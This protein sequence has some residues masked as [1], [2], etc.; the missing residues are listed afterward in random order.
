MDDVI[1]EG[2]SIGAR[3]AKHSGE[4]VSVGL[5]TGVLATAVLPPDLDSLVKPISEGYFQ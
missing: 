3:A 2:G 1:K 4:K 5:V